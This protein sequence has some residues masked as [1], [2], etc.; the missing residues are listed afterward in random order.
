MHRNRLW[1]IGPALFLIALFAIP[2]SALA[3]ER[4]TIANG[5]YDVVVGWDIE[6]AYQGLK[7]SASIR[8]SQA[9]S[10]PAVPMQGA[11][12]KEFPLRAFFGQQGYYV[13]DIVPMRD[14]DFQWTFV[15]SINEDQVNEKFDTADGKFGGVEAISGLQFP[16]AADAGQAATAAAAAA[17][18]DAQGART[19]AFV[20]IGL[21]VLGLLAGLGAFLSRPR[22]ART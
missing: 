17:Q 8:I 12:A 2:T 21:G 16:A 5:K 6:P 14:G 1:V 20:G 7:N 10:N 4:R 11:S 3:H 9:G 18:S 22:S 13:A 15:G 19:L